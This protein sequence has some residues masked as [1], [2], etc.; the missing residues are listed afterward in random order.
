M[1]RPSGVMR[2]AG[3]TLPGKGRPVR[4]SRMTVVMPLKSPLRMAVVGSVRRAGVVKRRI[5]FHSS[6]AKKKSLFFW[7]G[8]PTL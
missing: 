6:P 7:M 4:G 5:F 1:A 8:P 2:L 3:M